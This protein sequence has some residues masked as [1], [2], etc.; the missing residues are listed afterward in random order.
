MTLWHELAQAVRQYGAP[1]FVRTDNDAVFVSRMFRVGLWL[2]GIRQQQIEPGW[3]RSLSGIT[4][5]TRQRRRGQMRGRRP[6]TT[7]GV[8]TGIH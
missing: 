8:F 3:P 7:G 6:G 2:L 4:F 5:V 1:Q